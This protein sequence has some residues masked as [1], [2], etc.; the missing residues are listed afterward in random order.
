MITHFENVKEFKTDWPLPVCGGYGAEGGAQLYIWLLLGS[1]L[2][3]NTF[4][5]SGSSTHSIEKATES[6]M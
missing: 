2:V 3:V 4:S 6:K 5:W 1:L